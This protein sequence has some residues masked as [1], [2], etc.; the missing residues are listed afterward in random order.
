MGYQLVN[1][2]FKTF[3][4]FRFAFGRIPLVAAVQI[5]VSGLDYA[6]FLHR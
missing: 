5:T 3:E 6:N 4:C 2:R 1:G